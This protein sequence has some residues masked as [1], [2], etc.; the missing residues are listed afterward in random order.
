[1]RY[2]HINVLKKRITVG[3]GR[4]FD[5]TSS[6]DDIISLPDRDPINLIPVPAHYLLEEY[7]RLKAAEKIFP[8]AAGNPTNPVL[9]LDCF[10]NLGRSIAVE[11]RSISATE[12]EGPGSTQYG[13]ILLYLCGGCNV[14]KEVLRDFRFCPG[15]KICV[16][17]SDR[18]SLRDQVVKLD[19][20]EHWRFRLRDE[21]KTASGLGDDALYFLTGTYDG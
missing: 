2:N 10:V 11:F 4:Y 15:A 1:M 20:E 14:T 8:A 17:S 13:G 21:F 18:S 5:V 19:L 6:I 12:C 9:L 3:G 7:L 16:V